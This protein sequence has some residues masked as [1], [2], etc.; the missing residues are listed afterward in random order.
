MVLNGRDHM[1]DIGLDGRIILKY[2]QHLKVSWQIY[3][4]KR[5]WAITFIVVELKTNI[6]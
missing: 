4:L 3:A 1:G 5:C 6:S 2:T